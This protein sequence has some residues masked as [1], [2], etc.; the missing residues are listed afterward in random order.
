MSLGQTTKYAIKVLKLLSFQLQLF[1]DKLLWFLCTFNHYLIK[2]YLTSFLKIGCKMILEWFSKKKLSTFYKTCYVH[3]HHFCH[4]TNRIHRKALFQLLEMNYFNAIH[5][6]NLRQNHWD[7]KI[8]LNY[9]ICDSVP[10][11][12]KLI[13]KGWLSVKVGVKSLN[14]NWP[15]FLWWL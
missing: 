15:I 4:F 14:A 8:R 6:C 11:I 1:Y 12:I 13:G 7:D 5:L 3:L 10:Q 9:N 2:M